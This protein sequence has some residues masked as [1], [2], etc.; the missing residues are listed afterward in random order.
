MNLNK[1]IFITF[2]ISVTGLLC[3]TLYLIDTQAEQHEIKRIIADLDSA[4]GQFQQDLEVEQK[5]IQ[6]LTHVITAD[7]KFRSFFSANKR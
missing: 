7:Q 4:Q 1:K 5:H 6:T 2:F 3:T